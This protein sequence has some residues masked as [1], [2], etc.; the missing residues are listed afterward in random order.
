MPQYVPLSFYHAWVLEI[1]LWLSGLVASASTYWATS[2]APKEMVAYI[3]LQF[4]RAK[5]KI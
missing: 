2:A 4:L 5:K 3:N 1:K